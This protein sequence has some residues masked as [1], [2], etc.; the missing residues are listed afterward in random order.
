MDKTFT[1][2]KSKI[3]PA[4]HV[5]E[6][7]RKLRRRVIVKNVM[8]IHSGDM[9]ILGTYTVTGIFVVILMFVRRFS[10]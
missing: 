5:L 3:K 8:V 4:K 6:E 2:I 10:S 7:K 9:T 1:R